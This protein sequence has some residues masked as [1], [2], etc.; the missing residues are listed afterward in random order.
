MESIVQTKNN[1][2]LQLDGN[3]TTRTNDED[4]FAKLL[5]DTAVKMNSFKANVIPIVSGSNKDF[6][7]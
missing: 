6:T 2:S 3:I 7:V 1:D 4:Q 5:F